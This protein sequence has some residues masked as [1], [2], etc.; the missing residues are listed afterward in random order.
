MRGSRATG[1]PCFIADCTTDGTTDMSVL[2]RNQVRLEIARSDPFAGGIS[3]G[4]TGPYERL[5]G[6]AYYAIDPTE[7]GLP[8]VC[9][10]DIAPRNADGMVEFSGTPRHDQTSRPQ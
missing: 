8:F 2:T 5:P 9:D 6:T 4:D 3:F 1:L 7:E 10:L